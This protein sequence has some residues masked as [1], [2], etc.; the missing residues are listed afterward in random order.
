MNP[1]DFFEFWHYGRVHYGRVLVGGRIEVIC[2]GS[3]F[4]PHY[5]T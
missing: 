4:E 2:M 1:G 3:G 5:P